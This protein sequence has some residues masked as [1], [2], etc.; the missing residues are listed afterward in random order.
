MDVQCTYNG[1]IV[2]LTGFTRSQPVGQFLLTMVN[3]SNNFVASEENN[4]VDYNWTGVD[5]ALATNVT[6]I[7]GTAI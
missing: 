5:E 4:M 2:R 6:A 7:D 3:S 1:E